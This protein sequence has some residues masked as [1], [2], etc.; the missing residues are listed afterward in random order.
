MSFEAQPKRLIRMPQVMDMT[1]MGKSTIYAKIREGE[2]PRPLKISNRHVAWD[3]YEITT[4][5]ENLQ[6][7]EGPTWS[8]VKTE[9]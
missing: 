6:V 9:K 2:F 3:A 8:N 5:I 4:W 1:G 7:T